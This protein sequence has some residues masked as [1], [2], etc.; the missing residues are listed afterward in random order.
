MARPRK[1]GEPCLSAH[2]LNG[3]F[4]ALFNTLAGPDHVAGRV[5]AAHRGRWRVLAA[6]GEFDATLTGRARFDA[7]GGADL[8]ATGDWVALA[9]AGGTRALIHAVLPR[10]TALVR[11]AP[12]A[13]ERAQVLAANVDVVFL[14]SALDGD[15]SLRRLER[16]L[17][18]VWE[19]GA[20]P[21]IVLS[22]AD[23]C[24]DVDTRLREVM[25]I[26]RGVAVH[27]GQRPQRR[28]PRRGARAPRRRPDGRGRSARRAWASRPLIN[29]LTGAEWLATGAVRAYD[30]KGRHTTAR[31]ELIALPGGG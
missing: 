10:R 30:G 11:R 7:P 5:A 26:S 18:L 23:L 1:D 9:Q 31:R 12:G 21:V 19:S 20:E 28:R 29:R 6:A 8:P 17:T 16:A 4:E 22:K 14:V 24:A 15:F 3:H 13:A 2:W 27:G 25:E